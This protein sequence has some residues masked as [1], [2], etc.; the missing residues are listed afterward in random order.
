ML[1]TIQTTYSYTFAIV[2]T[3]TKGDLLLEALAMKYCLHTLMQGFITK[4]VPCRNMS[5]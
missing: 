3:T 1:V 5:I 2:E 4:C